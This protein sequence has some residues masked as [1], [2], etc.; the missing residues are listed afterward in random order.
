MSDL[1]G[2]RRMLLFSMSAFFVSTHCF[3]AFTPNVYLRH[4]LASGFSTGSGARTG[5][6][7]GS[8]I[9]SR[10]MRFVAVGVSCW[11]L[12]FA[13]ASLS[14]FFFSPATISAIMSSSAS[15]GSDGILSWIFLISFIMP[16]AELRVVGTNT[17]TGMGS[18]IGTGTGVGME[19]MNIGTGT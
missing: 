3:H 19:Y 4:M 8:L 10:L 16:A 9:C 12:L 13:A 18:G 15:Y 11:V 7:E 2:F 1:N 6:G 17:G 5:S 14:S